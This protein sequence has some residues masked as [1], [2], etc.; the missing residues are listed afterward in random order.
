MDTPTR[1]RAHT[2]LTKPALE[3]V[4]ETNSEHLN[5]QFITALHIW[6]HFLV[7]LIHFSLN[8]LENI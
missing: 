2:V 7:I 1:E 8:Y 4:I 3:S 6:C 5:H